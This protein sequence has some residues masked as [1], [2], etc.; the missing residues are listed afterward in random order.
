MNKSVVPVTE[1]MLLKFSFLM[2]LENLYVIL[3]NLS[4]N[5]DVKL[6]GKV[7]CV[8]LDQKLQQVKAS[9]HNF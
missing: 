9:S 8:N 2:S 5:I 1:P 4:K 6:N 3:R 7:V